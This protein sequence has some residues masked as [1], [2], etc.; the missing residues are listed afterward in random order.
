MIDPSIKKAVRQAEEALSLSLEQRKEL[1]NCL[2]SD[3]EEDGQEDW[4][5]T[6]LSDDESPKKELN[7]QKRKNSGG[8]PR[9][10]DNDEDDDE[11][12]GRKV[13]GLY[14]DI[15]FASSVVA[16]KLGCWLKIKLRQLKEGVKLLMLSAEVPVVLY[17]K[18][19]Q[20][21]LLYQLANFTSSQH[22][23]TSPCSVLG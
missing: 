18:S 21:S 7:G 10:G 6:M 13:T 15:F 2:P 1:V 12:T 8:S 4:D 16:K 17:Q 19:S 23:A 9:H 11:V 22:L 5:E 20:Q 14:L 3:E